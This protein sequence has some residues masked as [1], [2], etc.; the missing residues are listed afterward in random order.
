[1]NFTVQYVMSALLERIHY[2]KVCFNSYEKDKFEMKFGNR[3]SF[4]S[5]EFIDVR[6][7]FVELFKVNRE[8][9][10]CLCYGAEN[11]SCLGAFVRPSGDLILQIS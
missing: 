6:R 1:M 5:F 8:C 2:T 10:R 9:Y 11:G 4:K 3:I 7:Q